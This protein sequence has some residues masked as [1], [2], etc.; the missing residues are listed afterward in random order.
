MSLSFDVSESHENESDEGDIRTCD[1]NEE[2]SEGNVSLLLT[3]RSGKL[4]IVEILVC[5]D[6][7]VR[8]ANQ[9]D[10]T[11]LLAAVGAGKLELAEMLVI[12]DVNVETVRMDGGGVFSLVIVS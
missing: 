6:A 9:R 12:K 8:S 11:P 5:T 4:E 2:D 7:V 10:D 3:S 1:V